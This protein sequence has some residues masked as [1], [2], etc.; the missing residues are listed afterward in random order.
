M[1][2]YQTPQEFDVRNYS[3]PQ[4]DDRQTEQMDRESHVQLILSVAYRRTGLCARYAGG[5]LH[6]ACQSIFDKDD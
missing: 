1:F 6:I 3:S 5:H 2:C 4:S